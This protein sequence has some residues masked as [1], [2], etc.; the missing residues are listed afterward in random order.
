MKVRIPAS[1]D[2]LNDVYFVDED[3]TQ[4]VYPL[5]IAI[6][7]DTVSVDDKPGIFLG[8]HGPKFSDKPVYHVKPIGR[9]EY[10]IFSSN[11]RT[12]CPRMKSKMLGPMWEMV[13]G[14]T[15]WMFLHDYQTTNPSSVLS[16]LRAD[17]NFCFAYKVKK[18]WT[19][20]DLGWTAYMYP[21]KFVVTHHTA[22][23]TF[24]PISDAVAARARELYVPL[25]MLGKE[26][27]EYASSQDQA[28]I[29]IQRAASL[30]FVM[31]AMKD[32]IPTI[33]KPS[34]SPG[35]FTTC[36]LANL[37]EPVDTFHDLDRFN[38]DPVHD[39]TNY[40]VMYGKQH[41]F[42]SAIEDVP[43]MN[44]NNI[45]NI[46]EFTSFIYNLVVRRKVTMPSSLSDAWLSYRY[47]YGTT[48]MDINE[49]IKFMRRHVHRYLNGIG[50][51]SYGSHTFDYEGKTVTCTCRVWLRNKQLDTIGRVWKTLDTYGLKPNFYIVWDSIPFS[52]IAD[53]FL[54]IGDVMS[55]A[56][57]RQRAA[58]YYTYRSI[59]YSWTYEPRVDGLR[60]KSYR[61][62]VE[63]AP[64]DLSGVYWL[65]NGNVN[66]KLAAFRALDLTS[67][68]VG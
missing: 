8:A 41:A 32:I 40:W 6:G 56:D 55:V 16:Y 48:K 59:T 17:I 9:G 13:D 20:A 50:L 51:K 3:Y 14:Y 7:T 31:Q 11:G 36:S 33:S 37:P 46:L 62:W 67:L 4:T 24:R 22:N 54:P 43:R 34:I 23:R 21:D 25:P 49:A 19:W 29:R 27:K 68:I 64:P 44:D 42:V 58:E 5:G 26:R 12:Y 47:T 15:V 1:V 18:G 63:S 30:D 28:R 52:F 66:P 53:W 45:S 65:E 39:L 57:V 2:F 10:E 60:W 35:E 61:R 38:G